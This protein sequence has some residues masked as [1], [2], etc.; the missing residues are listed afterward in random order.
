MSAQLR[1]LSEIE[2]DLGKRIPDRLIKE[3]KKQN[4]TIFFIEWETAENVLDHYAP[5][6]EGE[7][8]FTISGERVV[9]SFRICIP[10]Q[11]HGLVCRGAG[12]DDQEDDDDMS[13]QEKR[14]RNFGS[15]ATR[16]EAQAFKRAARRFG[17]GMHLIA[18]QRAS[19]DPK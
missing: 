3:R 11:D 15:P 16:A 12:G 1:T 8:T 2:A 10:T 18:G 4:S 7:P 13:D 6:W 9:C 5:G 19:N 14:A 17:V